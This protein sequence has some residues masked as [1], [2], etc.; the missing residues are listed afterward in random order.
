MTPAPA[1]QPP[2]GTAPAEQPPEG[3][4][5]AEQPPEGA[6]PADAVPD[7]PAPDDPA[8]GEPP[9]EGRRRAEPVVVELEVGPVAHGG[10]CVA[11]LP[12][13][14]DG[15]AGRVVFVRHALPGER[16]RAVLTEGG[17]PASTASY[18]RA[19]AVEVLRASPD[20]VE[21]PC[22]WARA[23]LGTR[24]CGGC[25]WQHAAPAA[26]HGLKAAVVVEQLSRLAGLDVEVVVEDVPASLGDAAA[27]GDGDGDGAGL[28]WRTRVRY[29]VAP[30]GRAGLRVHRSH[31]V[32]P[33]D[34]C[35]IAHPRVREV[36]VTTAARW[37]GVASVEV[38]AP[39]V[40]EDRLVLLEPVGGRRVRV[41]SLPGAPSVAVRGAGPDDGVTR[42]SGRTWVAEEVELPGGPRTFRVTGSGFWQV[43]PGAPRALA[44]AV[45][46]AAAAAAG[47]RA[48]ARFYG[49][50]LLAAALAQ[51]VGEDG[52][53]V[54]VESDA[55]A[56]ADARRNLRDLAQVRL[57]QGR[58]G[59]VLAGGLAGELGAG[60]ADVVVLDPPRTG[61]RRAV[62]AGVT[63]LAPRV[64]V[65]VACDPAALARDVA[66]FAEHGYVLEGL[67]A[68][69]LFPM[70]H[71]VEC[72]ARLVPAPA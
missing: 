54:A 28:G 70:T 26:Q 8:L 56:N 5:P 18:W 19:D 72:V 2:E 29:A 45:L 25:D 46:E 64:V 22:P 62:V 65:Y 12:A 10:H 34:W 48:R 31:D 71:H 55:R 17:D 58:V 9:P 61:A 41:P 6:A 16:V 11:R 23:S 14:P 3:T 37:P 68:F 36:P 43:H 15:A 49:V 20:R 60:R 33:V 7:G 21:P 47:G 40:G 67:R 57:V 50:G 52:R 51:A 42:V 30:G 69:D 35:R 44:A 4:A 39:A 63:A 38:V 27:D 66:T 13:G 24:R 1:E 32:V 59:P 53:V